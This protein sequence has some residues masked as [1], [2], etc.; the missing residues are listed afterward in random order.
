MS[1]ICKYTARSMCKLISY[2]AKRRISWIRKGSG[3]WKNMEGWL[4]LVDLLALSLSLPP[5]LLFHLLLHLLLQLL[6]EAA[7]AGSQAARLN[8][9]TGSTLSIRASYPS[10]VR[11]CLSFRPCVREEGGWG[12]RGGQLT[13]RS[14]FS[15]RKL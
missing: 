12:G 11:V 6:E 1:A 9:N 14:L 8:N 13:A 15:Q 5:P 10:R 4:C 7:A 2:L 3:S